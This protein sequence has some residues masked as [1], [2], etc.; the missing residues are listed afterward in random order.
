MAWP[1]HHFPLNATFIVL[2]IYISEAIITGGIFL[3]EYRI[4]TKSPLLIYVPVLCAKI[5]Q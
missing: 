1:H 2:Y 3:P 4:G 5:L